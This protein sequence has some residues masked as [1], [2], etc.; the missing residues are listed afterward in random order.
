MVESLSPYQLDLDV[1][2]VSLCDKYFVYPSSNTVRQWMFRNEKNFNEVV[3]RIV[4]KRK[5]I[6]ISAMNQWIEDTNK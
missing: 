3:V 5:C 2:P 1:L 4:G 6:K